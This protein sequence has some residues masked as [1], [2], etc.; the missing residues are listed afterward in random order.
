VTD[1]TPDYEIPAV[2]RHLLLEAAAGIRFG[3]AATRGVE[4][5]AFL[6]AQDLIRWARHHPGTAT[7][8]PAS[9][10]TTPE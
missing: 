3:P 9:P 2:L 7:E 5:R 6:D 1:P 4:W 10:G 8:P